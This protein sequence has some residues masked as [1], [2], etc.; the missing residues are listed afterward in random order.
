[1]QAHSGAAFAFLGSGA[2]PHHVF[3]LGAWASV[4]DH[5]RRFVPGAA[6]QAVLRDVEGKVAV[7]WLAHVDVPLGEVLGVVSRGGCVIERVAV[8]RQARSAFEETLERRGDGVGGWRV[9]DPGAEYLGD[10]QSED[11]DVFVWVGKGEIEHQESESGENPVH[12]DGGK[13]AVR[14][15]D[16]TAVAILDLENQS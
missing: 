7:E 9:D 4:D 6:N 11:E 2:A 1:M 16:R 10:T 12:E 14:L 5:M 8:R 13:D 3:V 15:I